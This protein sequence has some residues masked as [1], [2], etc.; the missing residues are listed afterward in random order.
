[1]KIR[2]VGGKGFRIPLFYP[3]K[4]GKRADVTV[5]LKRPPQVQAEQ[6]ECSSA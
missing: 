1:V 3:N 4:P 2:D 6:A 5:P